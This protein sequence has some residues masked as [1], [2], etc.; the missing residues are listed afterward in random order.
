MAI[1]M[2]SRDFS[3]FINSCKLH[4]HE[5]DFI[6]NVNYKKVNILRYIKGLKHFQIF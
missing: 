5:K 3:Y 6:N 1:Q 4:K 2:I